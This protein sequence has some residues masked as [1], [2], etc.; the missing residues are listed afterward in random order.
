MHIPG[1]LESS[2][3]NPRFRFFRNWQLTFRRKFYTDEATPIKEI[4]AQPH[5]QKVAQIAGNKR[6]LAAW[7]QSCESANKIAL[8]RQLARLHMSSS[9][10]ALY[11]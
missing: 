2:K 8:N 6:R 1:K 9:R 3:R 7:R 10:L 5:A 11:A 4:M